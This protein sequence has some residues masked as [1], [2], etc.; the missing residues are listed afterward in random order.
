MADDKKDGVYRQSVGDLKLP[1]REGSMRISLS[2]EQAKRAWGEL[3]ATKA[4]FFHKPG[5]CNGPAR[6]VQTE[7]KTL[8]CCDG[9]NLRMELRDR[10]GQRPESLKALEAV[11]AD[12]CKKELEG[13]DF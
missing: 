1:N 7:A 5:G 6:V 12:M 4:M 2:N 13:S 9:C 8:L 3:L 11:L 10:R